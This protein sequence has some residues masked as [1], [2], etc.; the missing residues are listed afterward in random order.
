MKTK[1]RIVCE[2]N[3][4]SK[5]KEESKIS[6]DFLP[7][8]IYIAKKDSNETLLLGRLPTKTT[9]TNGFVLSIIENCISVFISPKIFHRTVQITDEESCE[10]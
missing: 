1:I 9:S 4:D 10:N 7:F 8:T 3:K 6:F 5:G 2:W